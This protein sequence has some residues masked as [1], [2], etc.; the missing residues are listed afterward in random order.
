MVSAK[1]VKLVS[2]NIFNYGFVEFDTPIHGKKYGLIDAKTRRYSRVRDEL[3]K[4][5]RVQCDVDTSS[6]G[7]NAWQV[8]NI[9]LDN[10]EKALA[11]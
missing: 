3:K 7:V 11:S 2:N 1:V 9:E 10:E 4:N 6:N 5:S 8:T